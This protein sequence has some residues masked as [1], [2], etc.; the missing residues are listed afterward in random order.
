[1]CL[2][3]WVR[4]LSEDSRNLSIRCS[5]SK[6]DTHGTTRFEDMPLCFIITLYCI[7][8]DTYSCWFIRTYLMRFNS[9]LAIRTIALVFG[10]FLHNVLKVI[11]RAGSLRTATQ[12]LSINMPR[13]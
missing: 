13:S 7:T 3:T 2:K 6:D 12:E 4:S 1:M 5:T 11:M 10:I 8:A 9:F